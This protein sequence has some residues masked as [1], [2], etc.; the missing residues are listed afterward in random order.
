MRA[1]QQLVDEDVIRLWQLRI[2]REN[3]GSC[4]KNEQ[5]RAMVHCK[6][7]TQLYLRML[8]ATLVRRSFSSCCR[9]HARTRLTLFT[10]ISAR[11]RACR[12]QGFLGQPPARHAQPQLRPRGVVQCIL[13][14][15]MPSLYCLLRL[16]L[17]RCSLSLLAPW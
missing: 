6:D 17:A 14:C 11:W 9:T 5:N 4:V 16:I 15:D 3:L 1:R 7:L 8:R 10:L 13:A 12:V 2:V